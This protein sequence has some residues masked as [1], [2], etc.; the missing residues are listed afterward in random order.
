VRNA[1]P[2]QEIIAVEESDPIGLG[3]AQAYVARG[4]GAPIGLMPY[5]PNIQPPGQI[6]LDDRRNRRSVVDDNDLLGQG[7]LALDTAQCAVQHL[8][9]A[10]NRNDECEW[11]GLHGKLLTDQRRG[12]MAM[13]QCVS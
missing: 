9:A 1:L 6:G 10:V 13:A 4:G 11:Y 8:R 2:E 5:E 3:R 7:G 12:A